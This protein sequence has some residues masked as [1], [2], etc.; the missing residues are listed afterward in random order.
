[1][2]LPQ[3]Y[4]NTLVVMLTRKIK[5]FEFFI[6]INHGMFHVL[7]DCRP[8]FAAIKVLELGDKIF[9]LSLARLS[10]AQL[11]VSLARTICES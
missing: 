7:T 6:K 3:L 11:E 10:A 8:T 1:M 9:S 5:Q 2:A 4:F